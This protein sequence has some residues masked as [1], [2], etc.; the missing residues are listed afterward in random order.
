MGMR[1]PSLKVRLFSKETKNIFLFF[2]NKN[3][4]RLVAA[5]IDGAWFYRRE[6]KE[7]SGLTFNISRLVLSLDALDCI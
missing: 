7:E 3:K 5:S 4:K 1:L 6:G 2:K